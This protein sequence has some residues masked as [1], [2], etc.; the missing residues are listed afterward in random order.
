MLNAMWCLL[1]LKWIFSLICVNDSDDYIAFSKSSYTIIDCRCG[2]HL[3]THNAEYVECFFPRMCVCVCVRLNATIDWMAFQF[4]HSIQLLVLLRFI[5]DFVFERFEP[6][7]WSSI[8]MLFFLLFW[9]LTQFIF[10]VF[11]SLEKKRGRFPCIFIK[12][13]VCNNPYITQKS[14][15]ASQRKS[16]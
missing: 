14:T 7:I 9:F 6:I 8:W 16:A 11:A 12:S 2:A 1:V 10:N 4:W 13:Y 15:I 5:G 3:A